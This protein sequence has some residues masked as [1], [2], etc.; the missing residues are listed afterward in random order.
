MEKKVRHFM[1]ILLDQ[2]WFMPI[3]RVK[4]A[5]AIIICFPYGGGGASKFWPWKN[6][7][8]NADVWAIKLPGRESRICEPLVTS[9]AEMINCIINA[10]PHD[11][12]T[13][14]I[15]YGHSMGAGLAFQAILEL[16]KRKKKLPMLLI[17]S[18]RD[19]P[20]FKLP[21][22]A[23]QFNDENL[24]KYIKDLGGVSGDISK[25]EE[26][27]KQYIHKIRADYILNYDIPIQKPNVLPLYI[28]IINGKQDNLVRENLHTEWEKYT[29]Y[30]LTTTILEGGHFF[31]EEYPKEFI[32]EIEKTIN[33]FFNMN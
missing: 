3:R 26:F 22:I 2:T 6:L 25:N 31:M 19:A 8:V 20:H 1:T 12:E 27:I 17:A 28:H 21:N 13:P 23:S 33:K 9:S 14:F 11:L 30:S 5:S 24:I 29:A 10:L 15:F 16:Q 7:Q 32:F 18:G 4:H